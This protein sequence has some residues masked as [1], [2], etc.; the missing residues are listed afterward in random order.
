MNTIKKEHK[1]FFFLC[2]NIKKNSLK[3]QM[4]KSVKMEKPP[5]LIPEK[6]SESVGTIFKK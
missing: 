2:F 5:E 3:K 1:M 4:I 6:P